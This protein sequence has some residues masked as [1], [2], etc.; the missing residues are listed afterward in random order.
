MTRVVADAINEPGDLLVFLPGVA[1]IRRSVDALSAA[2]PS[3]DVL[4][5]YGA[6]SA[7]EQDAA[8]RPMSNRRRIV[9][10]TDLAETSLTV[11]GS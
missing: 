7:D 2:H 9:V 1:E 6:L 5:L 3:V 4:P 8:L 10:A 11:A